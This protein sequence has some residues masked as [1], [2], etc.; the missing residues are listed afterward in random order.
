M[1]PLKREVQAEE[2]W[3]LIAGAEERRETFFRSRERRKAL[4]GRAQEC[5]ELK[6]ASKD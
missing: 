5:W 1:K 4:K 6:E 3:V 2:V